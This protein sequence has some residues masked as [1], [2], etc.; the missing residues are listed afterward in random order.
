M[1]TKPAKRVRCAVYTRVSDQAWQTS[2]TAGIVS[3]D[4]ES[5][6]TRAPSH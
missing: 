4:G 2:G 1:M 5:T 3:M 6:L